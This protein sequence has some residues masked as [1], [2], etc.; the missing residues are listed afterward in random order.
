MS[1][2]IEKFYEIVKEGCAIASREGIRAN[3]IIINEKFVKVENKTKCLLGEVR[4]MICGLEVFLDDGFLPEEYSFAVLELDIEEKIEKKKHVDRLNKAILI[5]KF[6]K[7][8]KV[9]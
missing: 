7:E 6:F 3:S 5:R 2:A 1:E 9:G 4:P 8:I